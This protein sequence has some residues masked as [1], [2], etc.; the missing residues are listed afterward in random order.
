VLA[1]YSPLTP[2]RMAS[3]ALLGLPE[4]PGAAAGRRGGPLHSSSSRD[5]FTMCFRRFTTGQGCLV[6]VNFP[7]GPT[8][9]LHF[10][11]CRLLR[12][13]RDEAEAQR[14][15]RERERVVEG[16]GEPGPSDAE[17]GFSRGNLLPASL[18]TTC[19]QFVNSS[20]PA[21]VLLKPAYPY[22]SFLAIPW[23]LLHKR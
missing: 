18:P 2:G 7:R 21:T 9:Y 15:D 22:S 23:C 17:V 1:S 10:L 16:K 5:S 8:R 20:L 6:A 4:A 13:R 12:Q 3:V 11:G 19:G 14:C